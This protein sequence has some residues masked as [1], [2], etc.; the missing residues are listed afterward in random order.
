[1]EVVSNVLVWGEKLT[2][3]LGRAIAADPALSV[4]IAAGA[5]T[6]V[7]VYRSSA[8]LAYHHHSPNVIDLDFGRPHLRAV[9]VQAK[10]RHA[11]RLRGLGATLGLLMGDPT[12]LGAVP[13]VVGPPGVQGRGG[14]ENMFPRA[15][16]LSDMKD[17]EPV[18]LITVSHIQKVVRSAPRLVVLCPPTARI[19][20]ALVTR[21]FGADF[22]EVN[23]VQVRIIDLAASAVSID[24]RV[25][26]T[27]ME[28]DPSILSIF[29]ALANALLGD[30]WG[31]AL[32]RSPEVP[33][34]DDEAKIL[35][36]FFDV[37]EQTTS[38]MLPLAASEMTALVAVGDLGKD[39]ARELFLERM[40][41]SLGHYDGNVDGTKVSSS[42]ARSPANAGG[43]SHRWAVNPSALLDA[44]SHLFDEVIHPLAGG[45]ASDLEG[46]ADVMVFAENIRPTPCLR[47]AVDSGDWAAATEML[48][49]RAETYPDLSASS[50]WLRS[51]F[52][53]GQPAPKDL[54]ALRV[55]AGGS[56]V[57]GEGVVV[58]PIEDHKDGVAPIEKR[59]PPKWT[60]GQ[61]NG[62]FA[63]MVGT[64]CVNYDEALKVAAEVIEDALVGVDVGEESCLIQ[65]AAQAALSSLILHG[66]V[67]YRPQGF[68]Y[69]D[70]RGSE[71]VDVITVRAASA[72]APAPTST[73]VVPAAC[74]RT[75]PALLPARRPYSGKP[76]EPA[77]A[78]NGDGAKPSGDV[79][80]GAK[81]DP[82]VEKDKQI[83]ELQDLYR[84]C[85]ADMENV[86]RRT[87]TEVEKTATYA[88]QKFAKDLL[89]T[90]DVLG[91]ALKSV[92]EDHRDGN[93]N[94]VLADLVQ[95]VQLTHS[96]LIKT[97]ARHG[98]EE[99]VPLGEKFDP[100]VHQALYQ[101]PIPGKE[102]GT[103][104]EVNKSGYF[105]HDR[106]LR[107]AQVGVVADSSS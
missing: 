73:F 36:N 59:P 5:L 68:L 107:P 20:S 69:F 74:R 13:V 94:Q 78:A 34:M 28:K 52:G 45:R 19:G 104:I 84:R 103:I 100:N 30:A 65:R 101:A 41:R 66:V 53:A 55:L 51:M 93:G 18:H 14:V 2:R 96:N 31:P 1:M 25:W 67:A 85:L 57:E 7:A 49:G 50:R 90:A 43:P 106:V 40:R 6:L 12:Q 37:L 80:E 89:E 47:A 29:G 70:E 60:F 63:A 26:A 24:V 46:V 91:L 48:R 54:E 33:E 79:K 10:K 44:S 4:T 88:I 61:A 21:V 42:G 39:E 99:K 16:G 56:G 81:A 86:R 75:A 3:E 102:P 92:P 23:G 83:A 77:T 105:I 38:I 9:R 32:Q 22:D 27:I 95:G 82:L 17:E 64:G 35:K 71:T 76:E 87:K 62:V 72:L 11:D 97:L 15:T 8:S 98:V 58:Y